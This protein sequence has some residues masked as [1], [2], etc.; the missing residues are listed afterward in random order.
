MSEPRKN[1]SLKC[2]KCEEGKLSK[3][4]YCRGKG[5]GSCIH[6]EYGE[7]L[8]RMCS[9]CEYVLTEPCKDRIPN[10]VYEEFSGQKQ[11]A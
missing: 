9:T 6:D 8:F 10:E 5:F 2:L 1:S 11:N 4:K 3:P 7:H